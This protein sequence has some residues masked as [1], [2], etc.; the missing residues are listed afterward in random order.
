[1]LPSALFTAWR[2]LGNLIASK[3][4]LVIRGVI[5]D[6]SSCCLCRDEVETTRH[7]FFKCRIT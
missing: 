2:V 1:M 3:A 4:N 6:C 5:V 7:L